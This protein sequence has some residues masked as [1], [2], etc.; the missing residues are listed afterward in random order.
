MGKKIGGYRV[1]YEAR[2]SLKVQVLADFVAESGE[3][4]GKSADEKPSPQLLQ[5]D[6]AAGPMGAGAGVLLKGPKG[7][8]LEYAYE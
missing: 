4:R 8:K 7:I 5:V 3:E 2:K 6:G 1:K